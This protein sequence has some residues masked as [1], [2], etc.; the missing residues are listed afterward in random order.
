MERKHKRRLNLF[1]NNYLWIN[2]QKILSHTPEKKSTQRWSFSKQRFAKK[3]KAF[4]K[5]HQPAS[6][7]SSITGTDEGNKKIKR[8]DSSVNQSGKYHSGKSCQHWWDSCIITKGWLHHSRAQTG[9][10]NV[11]QCHSST[12]DDTPPIHRD[13]VCIPLVIRAMTLWGS[14]RTWGTFDAKYKR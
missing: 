3:K 13:Q 6:I 7:I 5:N 9:R 10:E 12:L 14:W 11:K 8:T 4:L 2:N 1:F